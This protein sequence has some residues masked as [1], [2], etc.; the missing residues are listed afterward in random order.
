MKPPD[1][2]LILVGLFLLACSYGLI[3]TV[4]QSINENEMLPEVPVALGMIVF[5]YLLL[6]VCFKA[7][8]VKIKSFLAD[9]F[10]KAEHSVKTA[11]NTGLP[12]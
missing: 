1:S 8:S 7:E 5:A 2:T 6:L 4:I 12:K 9:L 3:K 10:V 11:A